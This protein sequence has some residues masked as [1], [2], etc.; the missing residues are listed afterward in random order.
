MDGI[1][2]YLISLTAAAILCG[3]VKGL[4]PDKGGVGATIRLMTGLF[5]TVTV[6]SPLVT[7]SLGQLQDFG[8]GLKAD[9]QAA[10]AAGKNAAMESVGTIIK[11][12]TEAYILDKAEAFGGSLTVEVT[13]GTSNPPT[14]V[15]VTLGGAI[16]PA[17]RSRLERIITED[18]GVAKEQI[19]W[20]G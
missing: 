3:I 20:T 6:I 17:G 19:L 4:F 1:R 12:Q 2:Q 14:P 7:I 18:L 5:L 11:E 8:G 10:V 15:G 16:S 13:L 9:A